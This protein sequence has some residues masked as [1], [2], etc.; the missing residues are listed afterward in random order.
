MSLYRFCT[1]YKHTASN[2][3]IINIYKE[4]KITT[5]SLNA[6]INMWLLTCNVVKRHTLYVVV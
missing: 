2:V 6:Q 4:E 1:V 3:P 5:C